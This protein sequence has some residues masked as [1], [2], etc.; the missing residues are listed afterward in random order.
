MVKMTVRM[1]IT[2]ASFTQ[3]NREWKGDMVQQK[4]PDSNTTFPECITYYSIVLLYQNTAWYCWDS[5][6]NLHQSLTVWAVWSA[7]SSFITTLSVSHY[8]SDGQV[9][10]RTWVQVPKVQGKD[11]VLYH[12]VEPAPLSRKA[13]I[14]Y[15]NSLQMTQLPYLHNQTIGC[16]LWER[17]KLSTNHCKCL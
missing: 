12:S 1:Q 16:M 15:P 3:C 11:S 9:D 17:H 4:I 8:T 7:Y 2:K 13:A 6:G 10:S 14:I 5:A